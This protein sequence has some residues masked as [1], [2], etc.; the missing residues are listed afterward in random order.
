MRMKNN[1]SKDF[2]DTHDCQGELGHIVCS[3]GVS[4][5]AQRVV[6]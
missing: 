4:D 2:D 1:G 3:G 5:E 6:G